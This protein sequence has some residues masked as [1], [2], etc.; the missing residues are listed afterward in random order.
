M[1]YL[2]TVSNLKNHVDR[3]LKMSDLKVVELSLTNKF[4]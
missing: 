1:R 3:E 4:I 2:N